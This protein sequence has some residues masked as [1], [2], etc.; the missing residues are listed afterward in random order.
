MKPAS[1]GNIPLFAVLRS[2]N[3]TST[4]SLRGY[5]RPV[6]KLHLRVLFQQELAKDW[7]CAETTSLDCLTTWFS[8]TLD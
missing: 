5:K 1:G 4:T 3:P 2:I 8:S 6:D 7:V